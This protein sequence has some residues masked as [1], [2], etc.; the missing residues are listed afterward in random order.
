MRV[1]ADENNQVAE[2][3]E[4]NNEA[5]IQVTPQPHTDLALSNL[6]TDPATLPNIR[7]GA[8]TTVTLQ[9]DLLNLGSVGTAASQV[10]ITF[11]NGDPGAAGTLIGVE[12]LTPGDVTLPAT[13]SLQWPGRSAGQYE[14]YARVEPAPEE[15][16]LQNN[17]QH[18]T[19][20]LFSSTVRLPGVMVRSRIPSSAG[21]TAAA[22]PFWPP[23]RTTHHLPATGQ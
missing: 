23:V 20:S 1:I 16:N 5:Y 9:V 2:P 7:P 22:Y 15:T 17:L 11:W 3:C 4:P 13:V 14:V 8:T 18:L 21:E 6:R 10:Q 19:V 12:T